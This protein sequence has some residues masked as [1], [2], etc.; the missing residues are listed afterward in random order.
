MKNNNQT[1]EKIH[2]LLTFLNNNGEETTAQ[3]IE[4]IQDKFFYIDN[5]EYLVLTD[6]E[7][8]EEAREQIINDLWAFETG[9]ILNHSNIDYNNRTYEAIKTMQHKLC[10]DAQPIIEAI[11]NN[12]D[13]F[14]EDAISCDGRG[15]FLSW[16]DGNEN[17]Q[18]GFYIYK[19]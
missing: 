15:H 17:E 7:A 2:A 19:R 11:I 6:E 12:I 14:C 9:F 10:E 5:Q 1:Q 8:D 13:E 18:N 4:D 16:Y 3:D